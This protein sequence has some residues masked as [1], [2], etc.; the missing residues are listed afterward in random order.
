MAFIIGSIVSAP[1]VAAPTGGAALLA[2]QVA[3]IKKI[4]AE[5][6]DQLKNIRVAWVNVT[7]TPPGFAKDTNMGGI[8]QGNTSSI[9]EPCNAGDTVTWDET[10]WVCSIPLSGLNCNIDQ[11]VKWDGAQ[12]ICAV[13]TTGSSISTEFVIELGP[14][15]VTDAEF[16]KFKVL[17]NFK[18]TVL[19]LST[20]EYS[21]PINFVKI[22][23]DMATDFGAFEIFLEE[24]SGGKFSRFLFMGTDELALGYRADNHILEGKEQII[25]EPGTTE[26]FFRLIARTFDRTSPP[27]PT[28]SFDNLKLVM[29]L[30]LPDGATIVLIP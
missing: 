9:V 15:M 21:I 30:P 2:E 27:V 3:E 12:W 18:I 29:N 17:Q 23:A 16:P 6:Q 26:K 19:P 28:G 11:I 20:R 14:D 10:Q 1:S 5:M 25:I 24:S 22:E 4:I 7:H 8:F 13:E